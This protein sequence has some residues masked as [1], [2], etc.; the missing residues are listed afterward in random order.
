LNINA[1]YVAGAIGGALQAHKMVLLTDVEGIYLG[2]GPE[3]LV[4]RLS[5][6]EIN[7]LITEGIIKGG[8]IP[9]VESCLSALKNGVENVHIIDGRKPHSLLLEIFTNEGIGTMVVKE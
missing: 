9:K 2:D 6:N 3:T 5:Q 7:R 4:S 8:M 1:D